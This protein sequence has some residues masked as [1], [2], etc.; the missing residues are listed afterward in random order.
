MKKIETIK[1][2]LSN[3]LKQVLFKTASE[4]LRQAVK[5]LVLFH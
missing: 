4:H 2:T 5:N 1:C 3:Y